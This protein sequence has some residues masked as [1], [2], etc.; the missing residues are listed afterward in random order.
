MKTIIIGVAG[1][2]GS[3]KTTLAKRLYKEYKND[4]VIISHD[5]YYRK[6]DKPFEERVKVNYDHPDSL[7]TDLLIQHLKDLKDGKTI[8]HPTYNFE[9]HQRAEE[10]V[11]VKPKPIIIVEGILIF[12]NK[13]LRDLFD[14]KLF[15]D[16]TADV[17]FIRRLQRDIMFRGRTV[18]S[19]VNQY[20]TT[21]K[22]MHDQF[23]EPY[24]KY[25]DLIIPEGGNNSVAVNVLLEGIK[26]DIKRL[27]KWEKFLKPL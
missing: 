25:A 24:K 3:G 27:E 19:V 6:Q 23:V 22:P 17:R 20:L 5:F 12:E 9:I 4:A 8:N 21:V 14:I 16:T 1:G 15:V 10:T 13:E 7:E 26:K 2:T 11:E 18:E